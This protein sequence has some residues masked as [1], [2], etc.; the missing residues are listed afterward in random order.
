MTRRRRRTLPAATSPC[1]GTSPCRGRGGRRGP[2]PGPPVAAMRFGPPLPPGSTRADGP[3]RRAIRHLDTCAPSRLGRPAC[4]RVTCAR[5][6]PAPSNR[7]WWPHRGSAAA[8]RRGRSS[9]R[10]LT[11]ST[12]TWPRSRAR[13]PPGTRFTGVRRRARGA[14]GADLGRGGERLRAGRRRAREDARAVPHGARDR[15]HGHPR[16]RRGAARA[17][18][19]GRRPALRHLR[20]GPDGPV[21]GAHAWRAT[22][23]SATWS[24]T[25]GTSARS[26]SSG[27]W[28]SARRGASARA[29]A[30]SSW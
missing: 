21:G 8:G 30:A 4:G 17:D 10:A 25:A 29:S 22:R 11:T 13:A 26:S 19:P 12:V 28:P 6:S 3:D 5:W 20:A 9:G 27:P 14:C 7:R 18:G 15:R 16:R 23:G 2:A 24:S 1:V